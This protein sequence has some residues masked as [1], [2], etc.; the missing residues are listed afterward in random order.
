MVAVSDSCVLTNSFVLSEEEARRT[1]S[2]KAG[3]SEEKEVA[4]RAFGT[5][6]IQSA[7]ILLKCPQTTMATAM[8]LFHRVYYRKSFK[9]IDVKVGSAACLFL[10]GKLEESP[11]KSSDIIA[12]FNHLI[13][14]RRKPKSCSWSTTPHSCRSHGT[15]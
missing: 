5:E 8:V 1:P 9:D 6:L 15:T 3:I 14:K 12:V 7:G 11:R 10:A 2:R 13:H 4:L